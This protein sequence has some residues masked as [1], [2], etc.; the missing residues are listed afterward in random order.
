[1][2]TAIEV[3][4]YAYLVRSLIISPEARKTIIPKDFIFLAALSADV[5]YHGRRA[6]HDNFYL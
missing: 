1:V 5:T 3:A 2:Q 6:S 4:H